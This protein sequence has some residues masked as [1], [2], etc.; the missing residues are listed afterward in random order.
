MSRMNSKAVVAAVLMLFAAGPLAR[1]QSPRFTTAPEIEGNPNA[2]APLAA[3]VRFTAS[4]PV[5]TIIAIWDGGRQ[6]EL[7][8]DRSHD[9]QDGLPVVGFRPDR[10]HRLQV[11]IEN[12]DGDRTTAKQALAFDAPQVPSEPAEFPSIEV[13]VSKP[14]QMEPGFTLFNPRRRV[15]RQTQLGNEE[16]RRFG[17][18]F[19]MLLM[20]DAAGMPVWYYRCD[21]RISDFEHLPNGHI[22][23]ITQD[24]RIVEIDLLGN[25]IAS[26][27]AAQRPQGQGDGI[28]VPTMTFHHDADLL[29]PDRLLALSTDRRKL[30]NWYT[31]EYDADVPRRTQWVMGDRIVEFDREGRVLWTWN[32]FEHMDPYRIGY[33]TFLPYWKRRGYPDT[34]DWSHANSVLYHAADNSVL[35]NFR[36]QSAILK[37]DRDGG[38]VMWVFGEPS[39]WP[40][41]L[42]DRLISLEGDARWFW[43]QH[44]PVWTSRGTLLLFDN[45]NYRAR[46][47][48]SPTPVSETWSRAAEYQI[49]EEKQTARLVWSS[50]I[51]GEE[52]VVT[53]AMG[54][55]AE[56]SKTGNILV[57]FGAI[58]GPNGV[59]TIDWQTRARIGQ[60][61]RAREYTHTTPP[62]VVWEMRLEKTGDDPEIGW[63]IFGVQRIASLGP[64][65]ERRN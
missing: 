34:V 36:L 59:E 29:S 46:P 56:M 21:S 41:H 45:G 37:I 38:D 53:I 58:L 13:P 28:A 3:I 63:N 19:G 4:E 25:E 22:L 16:E 30:A 31:S 10:R 17:E 43:H 39:G 55:V 24:Y 49:D 7:A 15:P 35:I 64:Q 27:Y 48:E 51:P 14:G 52:K 57:G 6:W 8:F 20:V 23:Y 9:P 5:R 26:W 33:E 60:W 50:E 2:R 32:A 18:S 11:T 40:E 12:A 65:Y 1:A 54:S 42:Q 62:T 44:A 61:T 47:F